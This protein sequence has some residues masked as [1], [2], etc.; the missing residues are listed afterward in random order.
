MFQKSFTATL[1]AVG[2]GGEQQLALHASWAGTPGDPG[3]LVAALHPVREPEEATV[4]VQGVGA[5]R[6]GNQTTHS[7]LTDR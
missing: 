6:P 3:L 7:Q 1:E 2:R 5:D 4:A